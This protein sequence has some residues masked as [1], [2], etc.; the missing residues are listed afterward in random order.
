L[1]S[2]TDPAAAHADFVNVRVNHT[3]TSTAHL[4][5]PSL[6][7]ALKN[8]S[9]GPSYGY[10]SSQTGHASKKMIII[11]CSIVGGL[12]LLGIIVACCCSR[13]RVFFRRGRR[14]QQLG[15]PTPLAEVSR[16]RGYH[17]GPT[18]FGS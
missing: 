3:T 18:H 5:Q 16:V 10:G 4:S 17:T 9:P 2:T 12:L 15:A 7:K 8:S 14:Y 1:L 11:V 13:D 6:D